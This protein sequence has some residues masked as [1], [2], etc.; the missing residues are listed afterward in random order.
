M[1]LGMVD[2]YRP[3]TRF[4]PGFS[5]FLNKFFTYFIL[6]L[7]KSNHYCI[8]I[9][10]D[11]PDDCNVNQITTNRK[12]ISCSGG[13]PGNSHGEC[14]TI[15]SAYTLYTTSRIAVVVSG[16][17]FKVSGPCRFHFQSCSLGYFRC[18]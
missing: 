5:Q 6:I 14:N 12:R 16:F 2:V 8:F 7:W 10:C 9:L 18:T 15:V 3:C 1:F 11:V 17:N 13:L 4:Q